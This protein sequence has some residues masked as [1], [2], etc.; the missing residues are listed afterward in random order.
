MR[1]SA[2]ASRLAYGLCAAL[3]LWTSFVYRP[4]WNQ[5]AGNAT[6]GWDVSGYYWYLPAVFIYDDLRGQHF[7]DS[8]LRK[9]APTPDLQQSYLHPSGAYVNK[10][11]AGMAVMYAPAFLLAHGFAR[12]L[13]FPAD[14]FSP[15]YQ[16]AL[17][18]AG[19]AVA[20]L[21]LWWMRRLLR[22]YFSDGIVAGSLLLL[23]FGSN[24]LNWAAVDTTLSHNWLFTLY[25]ALLLLTRRFYRAPSV[26]AALP[27]GALVGLMVLTRPTEIIAVLIPLLWGVEQASRST[28]RK[29]LRFLEQHRSAVMAA[30]VVGGA[31]ALIQPLY[32][33]WAT[34]SWLVYS[35]GDQGFSF[36]HPHFYDYTFNLATGW[37]VY[38]PLMLLGIAGF[39]PLWRRGPHRWMLLVTVGLA[40]YITASWDVWQYGSRAMIQYYPML[41]FPL[42]AALE[43]A[44]KRRWA[45]ALIPLFGTAVVYHNAWFIYQAHRGGLLD[46]DLM[47]MQYFSRVVGRWSAPEEV[48]KL[49]DAHRIFTGIPKD[50]Q[51][52]HR[53]AFQRF[54]LPS[55]SAPFDGLF[56]FLDGSRSRTNTYHFPI[57]LH[58]PQRWIRIEASYWCRAKEGNTW[59]APVMHAQLAQGSALL[60]S[61]D[62]RPHRFLQ[63]HITRRLH[64]DIR[65]PEGRT[66]SLRLWWEHD[67]GVHTTAIDDLAIYTFRE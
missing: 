12:P 63:D 26:R 17:Q 41:L 45:Q 22:S 33:K 9:Y 14:G 56:E 40:Y 10:Y 47:P 36:L 55:T 23:V 51:L 65:L 58:G 24:Y 13:G 49:K 35:Y 54:G 3:L 64:L 21:G 52:L 28:L 59:R 20:L 53:E 18:V 19:V 4:R 50:L 39:F 61:E 6:I 42:A 8:I 1:F 11:S 7:K 46:M 5:A 60:E 32:W 48:Q 66:D 30:V 25:A 34:G 2:R 37:L 16:L 43:W 29:R 38:A 31:I 27:V 15:P 44:W 67:G 62:L 57:G